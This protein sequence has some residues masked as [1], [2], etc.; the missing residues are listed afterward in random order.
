MTTHRLDHVPAPTRSL[1]STLAALLVGGMLTGCFT[2]PTPAPN[3]PPQPL[4]DGEWVGHQQA[5]TAAG[6]TP[7]TRLGELVNDPAGCV[8][9]V[10]SDHSRQPP[11]GTVWTATSDCTTLSTQWQ[12][13]T[14][15]ETGTEL[16][17]VTV[18]PS[19]ELLAV[20][21]SLHHDNSALAGLVAVRDLDGRWSTVSQLGKDEDGPAM[22]L[23]VE[24]AGGGLVVAGS[25]GGAATVW[26]SDGTPE[27]F[28]AI[29]LP[30]D[31]DFSTSQANRLAVTD[32]AVIA[33]GRGT[34]EEGDSTTLLWRSTDEG[35]SW[36][37]VDLAADLA[38]GLRINSV[39]VTA[40]GEFFAVGQA[41]AEPRGMGMVSSD[42]EKWKLLQA[43]DSTSLDV[44][45]P[46][47]D[48][49]IVVVATP[50]EADSSCG[51]VGL[52]WSGDR[53]GDFSLPCSEPGEIT[54]TMLSDKRIALVLG[55]RLWLRK[56]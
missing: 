7:M 21:H 10:G 15:F 36:D 26:H 30:V 33:S 19:N 34:D 54:G 55:N 32:D 13:S 50:M 56:L 3:T 42:G 37:Q 14:D 38:R 1:K 35:R 24:R 2:S 40:D 5:L 39:T 53:W 44:A 46:T 43:P 16:A 28:T 27:T 41:R 11:T 8:T 47:L 20:G 31:G 12:A 9:L 6:A 25:V 29:D 4:V 48:G 51:S 49:H 18:L 45:I 17:D 52:L 23:A 22:A